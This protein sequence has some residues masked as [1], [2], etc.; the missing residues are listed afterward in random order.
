M[1]KMVIASSALLL[2]LGLA[3]CNTMN[4]VSQFGNNT[5][6]TGVKY[7]ANTVGAG[8]GLVSNTGAAVGQGIGKVVNTGVGVV[9]TGV[10]VVTSP[11]TYHNNTRMYNKPVVYRNSHKYMLRNG[12]YVQVR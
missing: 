5:I 6:G 12:K 8:V 11:L 1:N 4:N 3:G 9:N 2:S 10:G 7:T